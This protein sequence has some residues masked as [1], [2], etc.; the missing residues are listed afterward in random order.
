MQVARQ[1]PSISYRNLQDADAYIALM[2]RS[3]G[4]L[5]P[6]FLSW[7]GECRQL[8]L[9]PR[10]CAEEPTEQSGWYPDMLCSR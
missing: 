8:A 3:A 5:F 7:A 4:A 1:L 10:T 9:V 6:L 2:G